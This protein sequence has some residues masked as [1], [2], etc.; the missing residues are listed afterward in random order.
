MPSRRN[1][2][3][4]SGIPLIF[5]APGAM[6]N[7]PDGR[8]MPASSACP[9]IRGTTPWPEI[10]SSR[11]PVCADPDRLQDD[12]QPVLPDAALQWRR[13][14]LPG[15]EYGPS[16]HQGRGRLGRGEHGAMF[17][18]PG[19]RRYLLRITAR[20]WDQGDMR[21][22]AAMVDHVH[23]HGSLAAANCSMAARMHRGSSR[24]PSRA[25]PASTTR[26]FHGPGLPRIHLQSRGRCR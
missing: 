1:A 20:I 22:L 25:G 8:S 23:S 19:M 6:D 16:W 21:N 4:K 3:C 2:R 18:S 17:D 10:R 15:H 9:P 11:P 12:A 5:A 26:N 13:H 24:A 7:P 14:Q